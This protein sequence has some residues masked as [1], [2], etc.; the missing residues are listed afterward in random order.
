[1]VPSGDSERRVQRGPLTHPGRGRR[2]VVRPQGTINESGATSTAS[3]SRPQPMQRP[4]TRWAVRGR[5]EHCGPN[6]YRRVV[7]T[8][9]YRDGLW[10][11]WPGLGLTP[12]ALAFRSMGF[13]PTSMAVGP[14][15][16]PT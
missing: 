2:N 9:L 8:G 13:A 10:V 14:A 3:P 7:R 16:D 11:L 6:T 12:T 15:A 5:K 4:R 1:M